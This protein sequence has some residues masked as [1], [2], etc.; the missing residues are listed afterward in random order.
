[1]PVFRAVTPMLKTKD[2][3]ATVRFYTETLGFSVATLWPAEQPTF[4]ILERDAVRMSFLV[5][6]DGHYQDTPCLTGQIYIDVQDVKA[7]YAQVEGKVE[8]LWGPEVYFYG[9]REFAIRDVNG[10]TITFS[11]ETSDPPTCPEP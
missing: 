2:I 11:E 3:A 9:R 7:W 10:Y 5:D 4:C 6:N 1:M 8:I